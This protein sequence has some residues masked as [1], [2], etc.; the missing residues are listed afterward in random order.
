MYSFQNEVTES[1]RYCLKNSRR[2]FVPN[3]TNGFQNLIMNKRQAFFMIFCPTSQ[4]A[5]M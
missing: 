3:H 4:E 5:T 2:I 1:K